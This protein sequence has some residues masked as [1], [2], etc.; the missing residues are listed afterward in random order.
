MK[1]KIINLIVLVGVIFSVGLLNSCSPERKN[2]FSKTYHNITAKYNAYFIA[3]EKMNEVEKAVKENHQRNFNKILKVFPAIDSS[4]IDSKAEVLEDVYKKASIAIQRH[5]NSKWVDDSYILIGKQYHYNGEFTNAIDIFKYV[6]KNS[7]DD[8]ARHQ[9]LIDLMHTYISFDEHNNAIAVSDFLKKEK[10]N[11]ENEKRLA[12]TRAHFYQIR[13]DYDNMVKNLVIA[14]PLMN[15][16]EGKAK[17]FFIIGQIYQELGFDAEAYNYYDECLKSNPD[18]ELSFYAKLNMAQV[19]ELSES[20]DVKKVRKYFKKLLKDPKNEE[21]QDKIYYEIGEFE[22]KQDNI[23]AAIE[24]YESSIAASVNNVRQKGYSYLRLGELYYDHFKKYELAKAYYDSVVMVLPQDDE[25]FEPVKERQE[26]LADFV[27][28]INTIHVQDSLLQIANL[29]SIELMAFIDDF[30]DLKQ[31]EEKEKQQLAARQKQKVEFYNEFDTDNNTFASQDQ[32]AG[33]QWYFYNPS[34]VSIGRN[35]F[36]RIWGNRQ[37]EDNWRRSSK[38]S[39]GSYEENPVA[40][41]DPQQQLTSGSSGSEITE[42]DKNKL[43]SQLHLTEEEKVEAL[44]KIENAYYNLG[45]IYNFQL[46][47]KKNASETFETLINRF[48][49]TEYKPEVLYLLYLIH[50]GL[51]DSN[52]KKYEKLLINEFP[53]SI[54]AKLIINPNY[55]EESNLVSEKLKKIYQKAYRLFE[56][57]S[58]AQSLRIIEDGIKAY[59]DNSFTD[60]L[61][62]LKVLITGKSEGLYNYQYALN[63][64]IENNPDSDLLEY[65]NHLLKSIDNFKAELARR[66]GVK[67]SQDLNQNH[68]F[69]LT[70]NPEDNVSERLINNI[71]EFLRSNYQDKNYKTSNLILDDDHSMILVNEFDGKDRAKEFY[72]EFN[73]DASPLNDL[74]NYKFHNFVITR[75]NFKTLYSTKGLDYYVSFFKKNY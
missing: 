28:Q 19:T 3:R 43:Y 8:D 36:I 42:M 7:E 24:N 32:V 59:P 31:K 14:A 41:I 54:Y 22:L 61:K 39:S 63:Q 49:H 20:S 37:L 69:V 58:L 2:V 74:T 33:S 73:G 57:D 23:E 34:A 18:Y 60:N 25:V 66:E 53:N 48:P 38:E 27:K 55:R 35:E 50:K 11:K 17:I 44:A 62:L 9:A 4:V 47:E 10:L 67:F 30:I 21:F 13:E 1:L 45:N 52:Q 70:Y 16:N 75:E 56:K 64:F 5:E 65:A 46:N 51:E 40:S 71:N 29:D 12:L 72:E 15:N 68:Y 6:N 26:I